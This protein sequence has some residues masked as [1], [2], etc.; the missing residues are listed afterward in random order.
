[1]PTHLG[2]DVNPIKEIPV[3]IPAKGKRGARKKI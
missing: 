3:K 2:I 1:M